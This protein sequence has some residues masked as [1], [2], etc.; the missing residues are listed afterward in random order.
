MSTRHARR[1]E[2]GQLALA[3][4]LAGT[5]K[6]ALSSDPVGEHG[7]PATATVYT[8][9]D[10]THPDGSYSPLRGRKAIV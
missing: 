10:F 4:P 5:S 8:L 1:D 7:R 9:A 6:D 3:V 2:R